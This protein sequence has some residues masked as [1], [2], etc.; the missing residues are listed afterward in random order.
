MSFAVGACVPFLWLEAA[1]R[2][3][4]FYC[5]H[6]AVRCLFSGRGDFAL[7]GRQATEVNRP[8][9]VHGAPAYGAMRSVSVSVWKSV[10]S[11]N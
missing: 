2:P 9:R 8:Y 3:R 5:S 6:G 11:R 10:C 4:R 1:A 7:P